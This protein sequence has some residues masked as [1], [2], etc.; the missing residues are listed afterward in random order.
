[1]KAQLHN[2]LAEIIADNLSVYFLRQELQEIHK[3]GCDLK[4]WE[5]QILS[6]GNKWERILGTRVFI[7]D[8]TGTHQGPS[9]EQANKYGVIKNVYMEKERKSRLYK[10]S[11]T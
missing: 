1:M 10:K 2:L 9:T 3:G 7:G 6:P 5:H 4:P 8:V 11:S